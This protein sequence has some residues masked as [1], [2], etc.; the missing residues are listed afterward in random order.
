MYGSFWSMMAAKCVTHS[1]CKNFLWKKEEKGLI[2]NMYQEFKK[3]KYKKR[4]A[5]HGLEVFHMKDL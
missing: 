1:K 3:T 5:N 2:N 4:V